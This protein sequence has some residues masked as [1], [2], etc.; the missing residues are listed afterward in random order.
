MPFGSYNVSK[1]QAIET[2]NRITKE[3]CATA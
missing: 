3:T 2:A 1:E